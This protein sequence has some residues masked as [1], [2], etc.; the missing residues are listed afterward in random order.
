MQDLQ[1]LEKLR[2]STRPG[3]RKRQAISGDSTTMGQAGVGTH[4]QG[5]V[6]YYQAQTGD[7]LLKAKRE[8]ISDEVIIAPVAIGSHKQGPLH[9]QAQTA[10]THA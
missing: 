10:S 1:L 3:K 2:N 4:K 5:P 8:V 6:Q 7:R 9:Y